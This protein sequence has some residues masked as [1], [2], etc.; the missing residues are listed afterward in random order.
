MSKE[1]VKAGAV[2]GDGQCVVLRRN[3]R[4][5]LFDNDRK[6]KHDMPPGKRSLAEEREH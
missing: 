2:D 3:G 5:Q 6:S 4:D 1:C